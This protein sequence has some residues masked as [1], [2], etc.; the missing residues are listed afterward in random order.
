[1]L[2]RLRDQCGQQQLAYTM[3]RAMGAEV[4]PPPT[5]D[6]AIAAL[7]EALAQPLV[8]VDDPQQELR[9]VLGLKG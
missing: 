2:D 4:D 6:D 9:Q 7:D 5:F 1:M 3:A 8:A